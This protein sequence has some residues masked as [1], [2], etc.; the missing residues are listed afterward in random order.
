METPQLLQASGALPSLGMAV[1]ALFSFRYL[2]GQAKR[3]LG[4]DSERHL[5]AGLSGAE[6]RRVRRVIKVERLR[7]VSFAAFVTLLLLL[8]ILVLTAIGQD[9]MIYAILV[10]CVPAFAIGLVASFLVGW[11]G[12]LPPVGGQ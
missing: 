11:Y 8:L 5:L 6:V 7:I 2:F 9:W 4:R 10:V 12:G 3:V 1:V